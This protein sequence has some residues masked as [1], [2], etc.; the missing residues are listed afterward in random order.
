MKKIFVL[1]LM[2]LLFLTLVTS[3]AFSVSVEDVL[4]NMVKAQ[5]GKKN[6]EKIQDS[7]LSGSMVLVPMGLNGSI[8][9]YWKSPNKRRSDIEIMGMKITQAYDGKMAWMDNP[10]TGGLQEMPE[11][12]GQVLKRQALGYDTLFNY[13]KHGIT[14]TLKGKEKVKD[15]DYLVLE[16]T[17]SD[18]HKTTHYVD[19][20]TYLVYKSKTSSFNQTGAEVE[21]EIFVSD[22]KKVEGVS[23]AH[24]ITVFQEGQEYLKMTFD[25]VSLNSGVE[26]S[27][28]NMPK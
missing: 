4:N 2:L 14:Y 1:T 22:Y 5:G 7:T 26:E 28:F 13:K 10:Q 21:S 15:K 12:F 11:K 27:F 24:S 16:Q 3:H 19:P 9:I 18:G 8:N 17:Y 20:K 25:K 23:F 6:L